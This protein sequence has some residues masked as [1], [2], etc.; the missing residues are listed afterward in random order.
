MTSRP[1]TEPEAISNR[2]QRGEGET[3][4]AR[5]LWALGY[6]GQGWVC[7]DQNCRAR[8]IPV[9]W[10][11]PNIEGR[12]CH[13]DGRPYKRPPY[14]RA[15]PG[16]KRGCRASFP[17]GLQERS[18]PDLY[19]GPP[20]DY[21]HRV[22]LA[23]LSPKA[24]ETEQTAPGEEPKENPRQHARWVR[25]IREACEYYADHPDQHWRTLRVDGCPGTT[26]ADCFK[27]FGTGEVA[28]VGKNWIFYDEIRF[29]DWVDVDAEPIRL[30]LLGG[31]DERAR[32]L[33]IHTAHWLPAHQGDFRNRLK[34]ALK[35]TRAAYNSR[36]PERA[37]VF[38]FTKELIFDE[39]Q[40]EATLQPGVDVLIRAMP[41]LRWRY[42]PTHRFLMPS[43]RLYPSPPQRVSDGEGDL[44]ED[45]VPQIDNGEKQ[46]PE[47]DSSSS[48]EPGVNGENVETQP[49]LEQDYETEKGE[50]PGNLPGPTDL[51]IMPSSEASTLSTP[52]DEIAHDR[53]DA[54]RTESVPTS[55]EQPAEPEAPTFSANLRKWIW[56]IDGVAKRI[57]TKWR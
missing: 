38:A 53:T 48:E 10:Q 3:R 1:R 49:D 6:S 23:P 2:A 57:R 11:R 17:L 50:D 22:I 34:A 18:S 31:V 37:W 13:E 8:M 25:S 41:K 54:G 7:V 32:T 46:S 12:F 56:A 33:I 19:I 45:A 28:S 44:D 39:F 55:G 20:T 42:R 30:T 21:P 9:A 47:A 40:I 26:Y 27:R 4:E 5:E 36:R 35:E 15:E 51:A 43:P 14:F 52:P 16:H 29:R 24:P